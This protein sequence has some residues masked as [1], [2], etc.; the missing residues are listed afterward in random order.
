M[1]SSIKKT[2]KIFIVIPV[3]NG[4]KY[5]KRCLNSI[6]R[7]TYSNF[8][9][10][11]VNDGSTD[12]T[13]KILAEIFD[14]RLFVINTENQG[15]SLARNTALDFIKDKEHDSFITF[16]DADD[17][18]EENYLETLYSMIVENNVDIK[19]LPKLIKELETQMHS[20]AEILDFEKAAEIRDKLKKLRSIFEK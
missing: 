2:Q 13:K 19:D 3:C 18:I 17:Y 16:I 11:V 9:V 10:V 6:F 20:A 8:E 12:S 7:Q 14:S 5:I 4:E 15:V 1:V